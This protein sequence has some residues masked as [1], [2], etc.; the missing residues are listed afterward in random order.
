MLE[1]FQGKIGVDFPL[2]HCDVIKLVTAKV[3][4]WGVW[5]TAP[6]ACR[7]SQAKNQTHATAAT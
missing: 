3:S 5:G 1:L 6:V 7:T 4:F 2:H